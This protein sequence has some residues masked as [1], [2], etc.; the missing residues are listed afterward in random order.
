MTC[1]F[2]IYSSNF[3]IIDKGDA[4]LEEDDDIHDD[5]T[6]EHTLV[7]DAEMHQLDIEVLAWSILCLR[8]QLLLLIKLQVHFAY[9]QLQELYVMLKTR[10]GEIEK[11]D[12]LLTD[13]KVED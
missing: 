7:I 12:F 8:S 6:N 2:H 3:G 11:D 4:D 1:S 10:W 9:Q 13:F 5:D